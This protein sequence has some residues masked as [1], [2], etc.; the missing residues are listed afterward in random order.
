VEA[1]Q[2]SKAAM[3][4]PPIPNQS[5]DCLGS[6]CLK[7]AADGNLTALDLDL[8]LERLARVDQHLAD[9]RLSPRHGPT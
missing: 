2:A 9:Q 6:T 4:V 8:V 3:A 7:W 5:P 1:S